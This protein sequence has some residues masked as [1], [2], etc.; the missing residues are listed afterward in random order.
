M[1]TKLSDVKRVESA[2]GIPIGEYHGKW[3]GNRVIFNTDFGSYQG[4]TDDVYVKGN[5][6][7]IVAVLSSGKFM[8]RD[9]GLI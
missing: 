4:S 7:C 1:S 2:D 6:D 3:C 9:A 8:V 5:V